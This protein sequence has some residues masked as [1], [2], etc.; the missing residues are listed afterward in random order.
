M[1]PDIG[2]IVL[3]RISNRDV[4]IVNEGK[5]TLAARFS[6]KPVPGMMVSIAICEKQYVPM[7]VTR[8]SEERVI[9]GIVIFDGGF[10]QYFDSIERGMTD[11]YLGYPPADIVAKAK[12]QTGVWYWSIPRL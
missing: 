4:A 12:D 3:Y 1:K 11:G 6:P 8:V 7:I 2:Q 10:Y 5:E 9:S